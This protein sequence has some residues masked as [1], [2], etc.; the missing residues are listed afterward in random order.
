MAESNN[1]PN[2]AVLIAGVIVVLLI[3]SA[4]WVVLALVINSSWLPTAGE[5]TISEKI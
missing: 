2:K 1:Q 5:K 4:L 3:C